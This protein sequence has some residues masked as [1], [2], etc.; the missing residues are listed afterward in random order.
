MAQTLPTSRRI[1][2]AQLSTT[3]A[4]PNANAATYSA[5][6][7]LG[8]PNAFAVNEKFAMLISVPNLANIVSAKVSTLTLESG[9]VNLN[10]NFS[11]V[12][13]ASVISITGASGNGFTAADYEIRVPGAAMRFLRLRGD[14]G[15]NSGTTLT[16][17]VTVSL[18]F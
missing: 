16:E 13:G 5:A 10:A 17:S 18:R 15:G 7:D 6:I 1:Q 14:G 3:V 12:S 2:D 4:F 11:A 8:Q 9:D